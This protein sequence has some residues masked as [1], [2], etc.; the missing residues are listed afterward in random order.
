MD[1]H[2]QRLIPEFILLGLAFAIL[3]VGFFDSKGASNRSR[4]VFGLVGIL[5]AVVS[6][7]SLLWT[8]AGPALFEM[9]VQDSVSVFF[10]LLFLIVLI[11]VLFATVRYEHVLTQW[12]T[13]FYALL[14]FATVG[15]MFIASSFDFISFY[16]SL[17]F[18]AV[19]QYVLVAYRKDNPEGIESGLKYIITGALSSGFLLYG[20]SFIYGATGATG[21]AEVA[22]V[23]RSGSGS[24]AFLF[25]GVFL[26][27]IG[28]TF[29]I[30]ALPFHVWAPDVYQG[31]PTPVAA[32]LA[33]GS[34][35]AG[36][37]IL[38]RI[39][40]TAMGSVKSEWMILV[41]II[42]GATLIFG[43]LAAMPQKDIK[44]LI[45]YGGIGS[46]GY[47]L[48][49][50][51]AATTLGAGAV[52][53]YLV[54]YSFSILASFVAIV[55]VYNHEG[56]YLIS[57]YSGL[58]QRSPL[59][60]ATLFIGLLSMAGIPP[61]GGFIAKFYLIAAAVQSGFLVLA[62]IGVVMAI[63]AM[64]YFLLVIKSMYLRPPVNT[65]P[66]PIDGATR[67]VL[68]VLNILILFLGVYPGP[69]TDWVMGIATV[70]F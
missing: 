16:V 68:Y 18:V 64:Y 25:I 13:E 59:L 43:N 55:I 32:F 24:N 35:A 39:L 17:E 62:V 23:V 6:G 41:A 7:A 50:V 12:K 27:V 21:F 11:F 57:A 58:S 4:R 51:A 36:F 65:E 22:A 40:F 14:L 31:A 61:L 53:F 70:L 52:M 29:K 54:V 33:A 48:M 15:F 3:V 45:A 34:K 38:M 37:I 67:L 66:I 30:S 44:R 26:V 19:T 10:K 1:M 46:A 60:A 8:S 63:V 47:L 56:S 42:S 9:F 28:I 2:L 69:L 5:A 49:A 20:I